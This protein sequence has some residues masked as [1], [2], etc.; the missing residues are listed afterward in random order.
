MKA[1]HRNGG[2]K[3]RI[4]IDTSENF[5]SLLAPLTKLIESLDIL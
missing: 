4:K 3:V 1:Q 5:A 2:P